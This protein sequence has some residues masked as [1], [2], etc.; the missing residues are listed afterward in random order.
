MNNDAKIEQII[1]DFSYGELSAA[2]N[3][4]LPSLYCLLAYISGHD[5]ETDY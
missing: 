3:A 5:E 4:H 1:V 2:S